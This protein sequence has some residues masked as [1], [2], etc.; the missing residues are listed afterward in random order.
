[1]SNYVPML[2]DTGANIT[3]L[4]KQIF[5]DW[6]PSCKPEIEPVKM[7]MLTATGEKSP[8]HGKVKLNIQIGRC[9]YEHEFLL[10]EIKD[11][12]ILGM[13]FLTKNKCDL[14]LGKGYM[15]LYKERIPCFSNYGDTQNTCCRIS[16]NNNVIIPPESEMM[17]SGKTIDGIPM[18]LSGIVEPDKNFIE[19]TGILIAKAA[20]NLNNGLIPMRLINVSEKPYK[21]Y[22]NT[23]IANFEVIDKIEIP[24]RNVRTS[25]T[26]KVLEGV[27]QLPELLKNLYDESSKELSNE[28]QVKLR[29]LLIKH[30]NV[31]SKTSQ[32]IGN[33][34]IVEH[35]IDTGDAKPIKLRPYRIPLS[36]KLDAE[37]EIRKMAEI[38]II[39]PSS[40]AWCA[41]IVM[42]TKK[43]GSIRFCCDFRKINHV[44]IKD[45]QPLPRIDDS[46]AALSGC[47]WLSTCDLKSGYWQ[48]SV[49]KEDKHKTAFAIE[50][51]G[52]WQFKV[53]PFGLCNS[54][55]TFERLME[56][57]LAGSP[58][59]AFPR[60]EG[61]FIIDA[62]ASQYG[63]G[64][65]LSQI[66]DGVEKVIS[67]FSKTFS[68]PE[69][70]YCVTRK[71]LFAMVASIK[72]FHHYL[73][74]RHFLVRTDH[75]AL[76]WLMNFKNPEGQ[77][78]RWLEV[79]G[80]YDFEIQH[81]AGRIH[82]NADALSRRPCLATSCK[83]CN[84]IE[85]KS[86]SVDLT[87]TAKD[88]AVRILKKES[89]TKVSLEKVTSNQAETELQDLSFDNGVIQQN[90]VK[91]KEWSSLSEG[92]GI[93]QV[94]SLEKPIYQESVDPFNNGLATDAC[95]I[96]RVVHNKDTTSKLK[97]KRNMHIDIPVNVITRN[98]TKNRTEELPEELKGEITPEKLIQS[99]KEDSDI[100][101]ISDYKNINVKP[102]WQDISRHGNKVKSYWNQWDSLEFRNGIL[103]RKYENIPGDEVTWQIVLP[104]ALKKV[105][106]EQ[107]HNNIT[108]GHLGIKK[109]LARVTNRFY[110]YGLRS[111]VEHWCKTCDICASKKAPQRKAKAP[112]K[113]YNVGAPLE[114]VAIDIMGPYRRVVVS[115]TN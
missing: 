11:N 102:G 48:V 56:K 67:Y 58:V 64:S 89:I 94:V 27:D 34:S 95:P 113:Q 77:M 19:K 22:E 104:K 73:Y 114:R 54:G 17:V 59:L 62:D 78:A 29:D 75:G 26:Q 83:Y 38:G 86:K 79:L 49:A 91:E 28:Q 30:N 74:G 47:R 60:E 112:M 76:R 105:V 88:H 82:S 87:N 69:R 10:A 63:M 25:K 45:C 20:V 70:Q 39:E 66:Q 36:K 40:S 16:L 15:M 84:R 46:L 12:G 18:N 107:L 65:V 52:F 115:D 53:M 68:K 1:M 23:V 50:G 98:M 96:K 42:V 51:G 13:D 111:D 81:R 43:D 92:K 57:V 109:T 110:W 31:F 21:L 32:D 61:L 4:S 35:T 106:M 93:F 24:S 33:T 85:S 80:T 3:I 103:C 5:D 9:S 100:K 8:F 41:P 7:N 97:I 71:E 6:N 72:N 90:R 108:S 37:E 2:I 14:M 101:V 99:Q 44:T 55:A